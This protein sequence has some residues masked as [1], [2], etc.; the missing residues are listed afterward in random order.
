ML[1]RGEVHAKRQ[2]M[3]RVPR[4]ARVKRGA[5]GDDD[6]RGRLDPFA[7]GID[8]G[9]GADGLDD[10]LGPGLDASSVLDDEFEGGAKIA[11]AAFKE[12][13][14]A[15]VAVDGGAA[16]YLELK[17]DVSGAVPIEEGFFDV[18]ALGVLADDTAALVVG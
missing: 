2:R 5:G 13:A 9:V 7:G 15:G 12:T 4:Q 14:G 17:A 8:F 6:V 11:A 16:G 18:V 3:G 10:A 1:H